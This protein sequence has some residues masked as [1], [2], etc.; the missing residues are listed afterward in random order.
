VLYSREQPVECDSLSTHVSWIIITPLTL[1]S[2]ISQNEMTY[3]KRSRMEQLAKHEEYRVNSFRS[4]C[5]GTKLS[6]LQSSIVE[7]LQPRVQ[8]QD[9]SLRTIARTLKE[10]TGLLNSKC[11]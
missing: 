8:L 9:S 11:L 10:H 5:G 3:P 6:N 4:S 1:S 2:P 7:K